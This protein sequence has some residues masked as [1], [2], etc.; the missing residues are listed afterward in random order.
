MAAAWGLLLLKRLLFLCEPLYI[1]INFSSNVL[2]VQTTK[3]HKESP[4]LHTC[5]RDLCHC[6]HVG[7]SHTAVG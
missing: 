3:N 2:T 4:F 5:K 6:C 7:V 1:H